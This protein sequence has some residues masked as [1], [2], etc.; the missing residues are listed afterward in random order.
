MDNHAGL[1]MIRG[2]ASPEPRR[3]AGQENMRKRI[4]SIFLMAAPGGV[5]IA[6]AQPDQKSTAPKAAPPAL[7]DDVQVTVTTPVS[8]G[9]VSD[10]TLST[11]TDH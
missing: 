2:G 8:T 11:H 4:L 5:G 6:S 3:V 1:A 9:T 10:A 7:R